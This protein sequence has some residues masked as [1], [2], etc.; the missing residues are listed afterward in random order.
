MLSTIHYSVN[1][2]ILWGREMG[3][4]I[5]RA[6]GALIRGA[7]GVLGMEFTQDRRSPFLV[8]AAQFLLGLA[9]LGLVTFASKGN[10]ATSMPAGLPNVRHR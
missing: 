1:M 10:G 6:P 5:G 9:G 4:T 2:L 8:L 3:R 7:R